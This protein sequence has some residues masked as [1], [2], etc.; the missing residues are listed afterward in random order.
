M[1]GIAKNLNALIVLIFLLN[2]LIGMP[3]LMQFHD[4]GDS[5]YIASVEL[6]HTSIPKKND[7]HDNVEHCGIASCSVAL[8]NEQ[9]IKITNLEQKALYSF[10]TFEL[11]TL[12][13]APPKRPPSA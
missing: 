13:I 7:L 5:N 9:S 8:G 10:S 6:D 11:K 3:V 1:K 2:L 12:F 4:D